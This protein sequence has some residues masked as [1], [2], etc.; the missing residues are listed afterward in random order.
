MISRLLFTAS[1]IE[2][3]NEKLNNLADK[4]LDNPIIGLGIFAGLLIIVLMA[5]SNIKK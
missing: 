2:E 4:Y 3:A 5:T 1:T